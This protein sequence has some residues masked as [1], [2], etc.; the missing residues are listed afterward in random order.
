MLLNKRLISKNRAYLA[1]G[2]VV[3]QFVVS[4]REDVVVREE[5]AVLRRV[6]VFAV[7]V[8]RPKDVRLSASLALR[9]AAEIEQL[10]HDR[11]QVLFGGA[12]HAVRPQVDQIEVVRT[13]AECRREL[14]QINVAIS[15]TEV[16]TD[17]CRL[18]IHAVL[19]LD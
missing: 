5:V 15:R 18:A 2:S 8:A 10:L 12:L 11:Q 16:Q 17:Q 14:E 4:V 6:H 3:V 7:E 1:D 9:S 19:V 13:D